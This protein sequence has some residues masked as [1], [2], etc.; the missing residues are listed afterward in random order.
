MGQESFINRLRSRLIHRSLDKASV[1][2]D[3]NYRDI[4]NIYRELYRSLE[5]LGP[6]ALPLLKAAQEAIP[7][8]PGT[9]PRKPAKDYLEGFY[10]SRLVAKY[11]PTTPENRR[12]KRQ[13]DQADYESR[14][15]AWKTQT[16][17]FRRAVGTLRTHNDTLLEIKEAMASMVEHPVVVGQSQRS[18]RFTVPAVFTFQYL[19]QHY[20]DNNVWALNN[21]ALLE[22]LVFQERKIPQIIIEVID[23]STQLGSAR[24][25]VSYIG[26]AYNDN[27][28]SGEQIYQEAIL[29]NRSIRVSDTEEIPFYE[30]TTGEICADIAA[31]IYE[32]T[33]KAVYVH[34]RQIAL[35]LTD[36]ANSKSFAA[37]EVRSLYDNAQVNEAIRA[38]FSQ[39]AGRELVAGL[40]SRVLY[41]D[42]GN[43]NNPL[44]RIILALRGGKISSHFHLRMAIMAA[45]LLDKDS[46]NGL[47]RGELTPDEVFAELMTSDQL[48]LASGHPSN[49][50]I[51]DNRPVAQASST[52]AALLQ[53]SG[54]SVQEGSTLAMYQVLSIT[55]APVL[56]G[57]LDHKEKY[58]EALRI[59][60]SLVGEVLTERI[61]LINSQQK[62]VR[63]TLTAAIAKLE[64]DRD[65]I[66]A[67]NGEEVYS[68]VL[69]IIHRQI[70]EAS[71]Q[72]QTGIV[73]PSKLPNGNTSP[74][75]P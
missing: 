61:N 18:M 57:L 9:R 33:N 10:N 13:Q 32:T 69:E 28:S 26:P 44:N 49:T 12:R 23:E 22:K 3:Q 7:E 50:Q 35:L 63:D 65:T 4:I 24:L 73:A 11:F 72:V 70:G 47:I 21:K 62:I 45:S 74:T 14:F 66:I 36:V 40:L 55:S 1:D 5:G 54:H 41:L 37:V 30:A 51:M 46:F 58:A 38:G 67:K 31:R 15:R 19:D 20:G 43:V 68:A 60:G 2:P 71:L 52:A 56:V 8:G 75:K 27:L 17:D 42:K 64:K 25:S 48:F 16:R 29:K 53:T 59:F 39:H 34:P 6:I